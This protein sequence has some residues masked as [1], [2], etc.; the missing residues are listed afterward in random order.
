MLDTG[1]NQPI[2]EKCR[3]ISPISS[4]E[5]HDSSEMNEKPLRERNKIGTKRPSKVQQEPEKKK[6]RN[7]ME[8]RPKNEIRYDLYA[9]LPKIDKSHVVRCK[10]ENCQMKTS[11]F[12]VKCKVHLCFVDDRNCFTDFHLIKKNDDRNVADST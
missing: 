6:Q 1:S 3:E 2:A 8:K 9:H 5:L 11:V 12:C 10:N 7:M 4:K